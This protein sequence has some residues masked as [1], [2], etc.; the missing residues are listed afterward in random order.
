MNQGR[1]I[2]LFFGLLLAPLASAEVYKWVDEKG[3]TH[4]S[5]KAPNKQAEKLNLKPSK[6]VGRMD[7]PS[8]GQDF[9]AIQQKMV[10]SYDAERAQ[11]EQNLEKQK[12]QARAREDK[13]RKA[14]EPVKDYLD[15]GGPVYTS[16][17][18]GERVYLSE[19]ELAEYRAEKQA[20]YDKYCR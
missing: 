15:I 3:K 5:D 4:F 13:I 17:A 7:T 8:S 2:I 20:F 19:A 18:N 6:G 16:G 1:A 11:K 9:R 12:Q 10:D 14:C